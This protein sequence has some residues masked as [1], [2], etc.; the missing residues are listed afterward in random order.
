MKTFEE[1]SETSCKAACA[2][3]DVLPLDRSEARQMRSTGLC[4]ECEGVARVRG[5]KPDSGITG[6]LKVLFEAGWQTEVVSKR[7]R[8]NKSKALK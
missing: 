7:L 4:N 2:C 1:K 5:W 8:V 6:A 3:C